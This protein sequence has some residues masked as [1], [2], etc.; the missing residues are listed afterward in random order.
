MNEDSEIIFK[1]SN[2]LTSK[3]ALFI[4]IIIL[5]IM[6]LILSNLALKITDD[7]NDYWKERMKT[8]C[9][10]IIQN[11]NSYTPLP[12]YLNN[13]FPNNTFKGG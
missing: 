3:I 11:T 5:G 7:C 6:L 1:V 10:K 8:E 12:I 9:T 2:A 4:V 13:S